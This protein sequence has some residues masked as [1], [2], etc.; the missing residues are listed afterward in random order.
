MTNEQS[1]EMTS[2]LASI[3]FFG[4]NAAIVNQNPV[5]KAAVDEFKANYDAEKAY[6]AI[7]AT[8][9]TNLSEEKIALKAKMIEDLVEMTGYAFVALNK[10]GKT[11]DAEQLD[12]TPTDYALGD[13][14]AYD[15]AKANL[16]L[17]KDQT[18][19]ISPN[20]VSAD[21]LKDLETTIEDF[22]N[23]KGETQDIL[24]ITPAQREAFKDALAKTKVSIEHIRILAKKFKK[25]NKLF[26]D[27]L[28]RVTTVVLTNVNHTSLSLGIKDKDG[29]PLA[30]VTASLSNSKKTATSDA[31]GY[32]K[33]DEI[34]NG[35][36]TITIT[37]PNHKDY[38]QEVRIVRGRE[39][40]VEVVLE[41]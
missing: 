28:M 34:R 29:N 10:A 32:L 13:N 4:R 24:K 36:T 21:D 14:E 37:S 33:I 6:G 26:Y 23:A 25:T 17:L 22:I 41:G 30:N 27:E 40:H 7:L 38:T 9:N 12:T 18:A 39:N 20:Y 16:Q 5:F 35:I 1:A 11:H 8:D 31:K 19:I 3:D 2:H 15:L